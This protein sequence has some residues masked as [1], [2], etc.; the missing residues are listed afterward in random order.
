MKTVFNNRQLCHV[1]AQQNQEHGRG[2][3]MFF[4][5][6]TIYSYGKHFSAARIHKTKKGSFALVNSQRYS[7]TTSK[8]LSYIRSALS[9]LM[10]YFECSDVSSPK[11]AVKE[12]MTRIESII[13][14]T[15][16]A[17][18]IA[19]LDDINYKMDYITGLYTELNQL[20]KLLGL[21]SV[22]PR[23]SVVLKVRKHLESRLVRYNELNTPEIIAERQAKKQ[24]IGLENEKKR[25]VEQSKQ[26]DAFRAG[27]SFGY[28]SL[29]HELLRIKGDI[30]ETSRKAEVP[31]TEALKAWQTIKNGYT[32]SLVGLQ[33]G[34][35]EFVGIKQGA[36]GEYLQIGCHKIL[37]SEVEKVLGSENI[38]RIA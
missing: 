21:K 24:A 10:P 19:G 15:L 29:N 37:I 32:H 16:K 30:I 35:F 28:I 33:I 3:H 2:N 4:D 9:G 18:K 12:S 36:A 34:S 26:I 11:L 14:D 25:E 6:D 31:L 17:K 27:E 22:H 38:V 1:F 13:A 20:R 23:K 5:G 8:H 7:N